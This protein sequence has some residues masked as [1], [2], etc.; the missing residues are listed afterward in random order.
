MPDT[1]TSWL[2]WLFM[3]LR[4]GSVEAKPGRNLAWPE[5]IF[6]SLPLVVP[7][8]SEA[9]QPFSPV[10]ATG[11]SSG[12][13][14]SCIELGLKLKPE[15]IVCNLSRRPPAEN[16]S[17]NSRKNL[18]HFPCDLSRPNEIDGAVG[19]LREFLTSQAPSGQILLI[20]NS[21]FG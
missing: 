13:G 4:M 15:L 3:F 14:K 19:N 5:K 16:I 17:P 6:D 8:L 7:S 20:N 10:I 12:S 18:N 9:L 11:G 1:I 21:G 2:F